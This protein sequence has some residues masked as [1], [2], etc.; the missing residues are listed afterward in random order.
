MNFEW[1]LE[2]ALSVFIIIIFCK[3]INFSKDI[4]EF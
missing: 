3:S 1:K 4:H 2:D